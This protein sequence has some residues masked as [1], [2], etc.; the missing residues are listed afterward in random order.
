MGEIKSA[1]ELAMEKTAHEKLSSEEIVKIKQQ[2]VIDGILAKYYKDLIEPDQL[3]NHFKGLSFQHLVNAQNSLLRSLSFQSNG[4]DI[5][6]R[7]SGILA[8]ESLKNNNRS[9]EIEDIFGQLTKL[10]KDFSD[11]KEE[12]YQYV[13]EDLE[14]HPEKRLQT[15]QQDN[16]IVVKELTV[17]EIMAQDKGI[18]Q[19]LAQMEKNSI[20][21][22]NLIKEKMKE[23]INQ[24]EG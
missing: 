18:R 23:L 13:K 2:E 3:W 16:Q 1:I 8:I 6:R 22:F 19:H 5:E 10:Q 15:F 24:N 4:Y 12:L 17:E 9:A 21:K 20:A 14:N 7:K 11:G